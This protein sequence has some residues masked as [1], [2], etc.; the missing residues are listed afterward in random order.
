MRKI[1]RIGLF[2]ASNILEKTMLDAFLNHPN[3]VVVGLASK[4]PDRLELLS[5]KL[6][7][8]KYS[9]YESLINPAKIDAAYISLAN[10]MHYSISKELLNNRIHCLVE[11]PLTCSNIQCQEII[12][13]AKMK[14]LA[15]VETFQFQYH[16]QFKYINEKILDH[17]L[18]E[19]RSIDIRFGFPLI[20]D[21]DNIRFK[22]SLNG[23]AFLDAGV[24]ISKAASLLVDLK[25][26]NTLSKIKYIKGIEVD[27]YGSC[28]IT[29]K[30]DC[31]ILGSWGFDNDYACSLELWFS[32]GHLKANRVFTAKK[33]YKA[34]IDVSYGDDKLIH[35]FVD[36]QYYNTLEEFF[37]TIQSQIKMNNHYSANLIQSELM[38][39]I[40]LDEN[41]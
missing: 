4:S 38:N 18:G 19:L 11:K 15:L 9:S 39:K 1:I 7:C 3:F 16:S 13:I 31:S 34:K 26:V 33:E 12:E 41:A 8:Q 29:T 24:Y 35:E 25:E 22:K 21:K 10:S 36:D 14:R 20:K 23:G 6:K 40:Y 37:L 30:N 27:M 2:G 5:K 17:S 28:L 32:K